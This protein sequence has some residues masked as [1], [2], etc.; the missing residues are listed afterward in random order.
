MIA[1]DVLK[2]NSS[3]FDR[4]FA[5]V[6][7]FALKDFFFTDTRGKLNHG[8]LVDSHS[9]ERRAVILSGQGKWNVF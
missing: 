4:G 7:Q 6:V 3:E 1:Q 9:A 8:I 2:P 5:A